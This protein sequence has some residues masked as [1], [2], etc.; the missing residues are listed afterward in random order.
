MDKQLKR[1][2]SGRMIAGV[3]TGLGAY[4]SID[5]TLVRVIFVVLAIVSFALG[6]IL[7]Y[8]A[9]WLIMPMDSEDGL[10]S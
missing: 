7:L 9:L 2:E 4:F 10:G 3:C 5:P 6:S 1:I 8:G